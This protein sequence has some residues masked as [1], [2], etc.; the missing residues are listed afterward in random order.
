M[1]KFALFPCRCW[2]VSVLFW[3]GA[4]L[5]SQAASGS[6]PN[7]QMLKLQSDGAF[8][9]DGVL[10][11][12]T[13]FDSNWK[14]TE[15]TALRPD[16]TA[17]PGA[18]GEWK[19]IGPM[20]AP[21]SD[22]PI[23]LK[24]TFRREGNRSIRVSYVA[25][26]A[27]GVPAENFC[28]DLMVPVNY[29]AGNSVRVD[30]QVVEMPLQFQKVQLVS[31]AA[32]TVVLPTASGTLTLKG[33]SRVLIQDNRKWG[34]GYFEVRLEF[35]GRKGAL[36]HAELSLDVTYE[37]YAS[38]PISLASVT[39]RSFAD[40]KL[41]DGKG[42]WSDEGSGN[43]M[44]PLPLG[45]LTAAGVTFDIIDPAKNR[46][47]SCVVLSQ[48]KKQSPL[49][50][51]TFAVT[52]SPA[53]SHLYLLHATACTPAG[54]MVVGKAT[55]AYTD[56]TKTTQEIKTYREVGNWWSPSAMSNGAVGW[57]G[58]NKSA[59]IGLYVSHFTIEKKP[60]KEITLEATGPTAWLIVGASGSSD[61]VRFDTPTAG[62]FQL[63]EGSDWKPY[64]YAL[65]IKPGSV[66]DFS[67]LNEAPA[68]K[69]GPIRITSAGHF[70]FEK[71]PGESVRFYGVNLC[72]SANYLSKEQADRVADLLSRSGYNVVRFHHYDGE[73]LKKDGSSYEFD[74]VKLDQLDYFFAALKARGI[75]INI[76]LYTLRKFSPTEIPDLGQE[77]DGKEIKALMP[78][79][80]RAVEVFSLFAKNLLTHVNPYTKMSW[81]S[82][83][84]LVG[85]CPV[86]EV[87]LLE[88]PEKPKELRALYE[89]AF[90]QW[91]TKQDPAIAKDRPSA[92]MRFL[93]EIQ[94]KLDVKLFAHLKS[95]GVVA[96]LTGSNWK[97]AQMLSYLR[98]HYEYVDNHMY[99]DHPE[100]TEKQW[101]LPFRFA[102][103]SATAYSAGVPRDLFASRLFGK[104][105]TI[106]EFNYVCPN[107]FRAEGGLLM[108]A[109]ASLQDWD[110]LYNFDYACGSVQLT[111]PKQAGTFDLA[112]DPIG[113][114]ADRFGALIFRRRDVEPARKTI[115]FVMTSESVYAPGESRVKEF[116]RNYS[117]L[118]LVSRI[119]VAD[120]GS[121][122]KRPRAKA[123][124]LVMESP[125]PG[126]YDANEDLFAPLIKDGILPA[127][128]YQSGQGYRSDTGQIALNTEKGTLQVVTDRME[129][130]VLS[131]D[132][133]LSG[134][135]VSVAN[136]A[137][138][139]T[140][141]VVSVDGKPLAQ[142]D[143]ILI[144]HLTD[145]LNAKIR[146]ADST[147]R[148][149]LNYGSL[150][151]L[152][153]RGSVDVK[154]KLSD[155][156]PK[157]WK[158]WQVNP[159]GERVKAQS[160]QRQ[161]SDLALHLETVLEN[162][163][164][165]SY[166]LVRE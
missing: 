149:L 131:A 52:G 32:K 81:A 151:H 2:I 89:K 86:N 78:I 37:P 108:S 23:Q 20:P 39:T 58:V 80:D 41:N 163:T 67:K 155:A 24:E 95:L 135:M 120:T 109:Y 127:T 50:Q 3:V 68:G 48:S 121:D 105:Y 31:K 46:G 129:G 79:S 156:G 144:L 9:F 34:F 62:E 154:L 142:S 38:T 75:Y 10:F 145:S 45:P 64:S 25:D 161:G 138:F 43:D 63:V 36:Q 57:T 128:A 19:F 15:Q 76:D 71:K 77:I 18:N 49:S 92:V 98:E 72:F 104:P 69:Y 73:L 26:H 139:A 74:P 152:V 59:P 103:T 102:Q 157:T 14:R 136:D 158:A 122:A 125:K 147:R 29:M 140:L 44:S 134:K 164:C 87:S 159:S 160:L 166:E 65:E 150:P 5:A 94:Q 107:G 11:S 21:G 137:G 17:V 6:N 4:L 42:G 124:A 51:A 53:Y 54:S 90:E 16:S 119:G 115:G 101:S 141:Y 35:P 118:G 114:L 66:F 126:F 84:A 61:Y 22:Q 91:L 33:L 113:L 88:F 148:L 162:E 40:D 146:F 116:S 112:V 70:E 117:M 110:A 1:S 8:V 100:F 130:F 153:R 7:V 106:S 12:V 82:D 30:E 60:I 56:G 13:H 55:V 111:G 96:P 99:W 83:S 123:D 27:S 143:R 165:L 132:A 133:Q 28:M 47:T 93:V 97:T 85:I